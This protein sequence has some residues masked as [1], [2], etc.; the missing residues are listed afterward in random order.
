MLDTRDDSFDWELQQMRCDLAALNVE[1]KLCKV[2]H[3][4]R[5]YSPGQP[6]VPA[7]SPD[8]GRWTSGRGGVGGGG[9][10]DDSAEA[11]GAPEG[12]DASASE[13]L[14]EGRSASSND[15]EPP[16][17]PEEEPATAKERYAFQVSR[18][19][20]RQHI[21]HTRRPG[22]VSTKISGLGR[23]PERV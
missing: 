5:K 15:E 14:A 8:G 9:G 13:S 10:T 11:D 23:C 2:I 12:E 21:H 16:K 6:R 1:L 19:I 20:G 4:L 18:Q 3:L 17:I 22:V 7:G